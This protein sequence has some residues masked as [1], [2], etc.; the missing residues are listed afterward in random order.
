MATSRT[1][2]PAVPTSI[3]TTDDA[4]LG[5]IFSRTNLANPISGADV[6]GTPVNDSTITLSVSIDGIVQTGTFTTNQANDETVSLAFTGIGGAGGGT[7]GGDPVTS[8][9]IVGNNIKLLLQSG[10]EVDID[11]TDLVTTPELATAIAALN[12]PTMLTDLGQV[13]NAL[14]TTGQILQVD[15]AG[16]SLEFA[17][18]PSASVSVASFDNSGNVDFTAGTGSTVEANYQG[19]GASGTGLST[20]ITSGVQSINVTATGLSLSFNSTTGAL[21]IGN[22]G[23]PTPA[24]GARESL[25]APPGNA[26][27]APT[28]PTLTITPNS[29]TTVDT[30]TSMITGTVNGTSIS[31][32]ANTITI[33]TAVS[34]TTPPITVTFPASTTGAGDY[35]DPGTY[36]VETTGTG[37]NPDGTTTS[38]NIP[39]QTFTRFLPFFFVR[40]TQPASQTD[41]TAGTESSAALNV[42]ADESFNVTVPAGTGNLYLAAPASLLS[43]TYT[44]RASNPTTGFRLNNRM[45]TPAISVTPTGTGATATSYNI[46]QIAGS[47]VGSTIY[48]SR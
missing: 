41:L 43:G 30:L 24:A 36:T 37:T 47:A 35:A 6:N 3:G 10:S 32:P 29:G 23:A 9:S 5:G 18:A 19:L 22:T 33:P 45:V 21:T 28:P 48:F 27:M 14:G 38:L 25:T 44:V 13:P 11:I 8:G 16:T 42:A 7:G 46:Y 1:S 15:Q 39:D 4:S 26:L 2:I 12:I 40:G 34:G 17:N 20:S 31:I